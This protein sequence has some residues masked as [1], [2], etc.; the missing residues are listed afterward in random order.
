LRSVAIAWLCIGAANAATAQIK[1]SDAAT[2]GD[3]G[4]SVHFEK[5][6]KDAAK[7]AL[8]EEKLVMVLH[9]SGLFEDSDYT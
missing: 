8:K 3:Y 5:S 1:P 4:T 7:K 2:C 6:P 9:I